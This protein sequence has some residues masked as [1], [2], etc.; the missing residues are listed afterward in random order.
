MQPAP[1]DVLPNPRRAHIPFRRALRHPLEILTLAVAII[2]SLVLLG[3]A[4]AEV[5]AAFDEDREPNV[6]ALLMIAAPLVVWLGRGQL[7]AGQRLRGVKLTPEQFPEAYGMLVDA[8]VRSGLTYVPDA[9]VVL[10]NGQINAGASGHGFRRFVF[11]NSDLLEVGGAARRPEALRFVI[12]HEVGHIAAGHASYW[13]ILAS[14]AS[15]WIPFS[16]ALLSRAQEYTVDNYGFALA[17]EGAPAAMATLA[18]GKYLGPVVDVDAMADRATTEPGFFVWLVNALSTH[19]ALLWRIH[20][21][22]DRRTPGRLLW[23]PRT[24]SPWAHLERPGAFAIPPEIGF[25]P[26]PRGAPVPPPAPPA[27]GNG[28]LGVGRP[29]RLTPQQ[30]AELTPPSGPPATSGAEPEPAGTHPTA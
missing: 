9:Y 15:Q 1:M 17:P 4:I 25:E 19:P 22:R 23:R 7:W 27:D 3:V 16:G 21:L 10:G 11:V 5:T 13:R 24:P 8:A 29:A 26:T 14:I 12:A 20:A 18:G 28:H 6:Y 30:L 2:T